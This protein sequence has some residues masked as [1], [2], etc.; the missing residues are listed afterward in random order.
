MNAPAYNPAAGGPA[1][2]D[3]KPPS[4]EREALITKLRKHGPIE[5]AG[6]YLDAADM[7]A[8][9]APEQLLQSIAEFGELQ[10]Q[11]PRARELSDENLDDLFMKH[12]STR[13]LPDYREF[14]RA[15][16]AARSK[17]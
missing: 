4:G 11:L 10:N 8:A 17:S 5:K 16:L 14:A 6:L 3:A 1:A 2:I 13:V 12:M 7:L 15:V 9:D